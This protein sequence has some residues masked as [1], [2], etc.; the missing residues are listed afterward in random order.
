MHVYHSELKL[1]I[2]EKNIAR[3]QHTTSDSDSHDNVMKGEI[4]EPR[5]LFD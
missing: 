4:I 3:I 1:R 5:Q 2:I